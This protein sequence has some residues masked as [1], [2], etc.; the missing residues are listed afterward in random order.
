MRMSWKTV[1][2]IKEIYPQI[3]LDCRQRTCTKY[4]YQRTCK[5]CTF[6]DKTYDQFIKESKMSESLK[7]YIGAKII[8]A[9]PMDGNQ[10]NADYRNGQTEYA[11]GPDGY[12][13]Q[14]SNP[15]GSKYD[16]WSPK[17]VFERAYRQVGEDELEMLK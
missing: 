11:K 15:D 1:K 6:P 17:D 2:E 13:V 8:M 4:Q 3:Y 12:H 10:F 16:S 5:G 7:P 14:Y 9:E